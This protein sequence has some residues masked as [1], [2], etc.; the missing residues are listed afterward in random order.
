MLNLQK[1]L[2]VPLAIS[3]ML[4][5]PLRGQSS[6]QVVIPE[7]S[8]ENAAQNADALPSPA[9]ISEYDRALFVLEN[10]LS[11]QWKD[12]N[13]YLKNFDASSDSGS[14]GEHLTAAKAHVRVLLVT[15]LRIHEAWDEGPPIGIE[16]QK[17]VKE[18]K[19]LR[20]R[21]LQQEN[22]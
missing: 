14:S 12:R 13:D 1:F 11:A 17:A 16:V 5:I 6:P 9:M 7:P 2:I 20:D 10:G 4:S 22:K 19:G 3:L 8:E 15:S 18:L 21:L